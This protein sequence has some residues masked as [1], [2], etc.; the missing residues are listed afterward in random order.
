MNIFSS[1]IPE[2]IN[3]L[4]F[5]GMRGVGMSALAI[6]SKGMGYSVSG[7]DVVS[8]Y[9]ATGESLKKAGIHCAEGFDASHVT[10]EIDLVIVGAAFGESNSEIRAAIDQGVPLITYSAWL[11][12]LL[13]GKE[14]IAVAGIHGKTT[15]TSW[16]AALF[17]WARRD[18]TFLIGAGTVPDLG[19]NAHAGKGSLI[20]VEADEY[21]VSPNDHRP[22]IWD[23]HPRVAIITSIEWDH[24]DVFPSLDAVRSAFVTWMNQMSSDSTIIVHGD[25]PQIQQALR[26]TQTN[27]HIETYGLSPKNDWSLST[28]PALSLLPTPAPG[29]ITILRHGK[30]WLSTTIGR[31]GIHNRLNALA[32]VAVGDF[33]GV[34]KEVIA[35]TL[36]Q[37]QGAERRFDVRE[38]DGVTWVDDYAHHPTAIRLT[39]EA[40]RER[41]PGRRIIALFQP[42]TFSR[43]EALLHEFAMSFSSADR[44]ILLPIFGSAREKMGT[45][46]SG[47]IRDLMP[48]PEEV[49]LPNSL[50]EASDLL[51]T[52]MQ[53]GD[54]VLTIGAGDIFLIRDQALKRRRS[55]P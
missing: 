22:K 47:T 27:A 16:I 42:H 25:D 9:G 13:V 39:L 17:L 54:V 55:T 41:Y 35:K 2:R 34:S 18:P 40:A 49:L 6:I 4:H 28:D 8:A 11:G 29:M 20:V 51:E 36:V 52:I 5:I 30:P 45:I 10:P 33:E 50:D 48:H 23:L 31:P 14:S 12:H 46:T 7:S 3:R 24:P 37:F 1:T 43:T 32:V 19:T 38:V 26:E 21:H 15:T 44:V 53:N